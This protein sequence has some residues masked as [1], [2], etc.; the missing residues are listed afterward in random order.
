MVSCETYYFIE[1]LLENRTKPI[2]YQSD[3]VLF[4]IL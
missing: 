3:F 1:K 2:D 4:F